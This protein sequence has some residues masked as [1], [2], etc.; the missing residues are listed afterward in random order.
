MPQVQ[1]SRGSL[2]RVDLDQPDLL[3]AITKG[4]RAKASCRLTSGFTSFRHGGIT[5]IGDSGEANTRAVSAHAKLDTTTIYD[6]A[7]IEKARSIARAGARM[8]K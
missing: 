6:K 3:A 1:S 5:E 4:V 2:R 7:N 8:S